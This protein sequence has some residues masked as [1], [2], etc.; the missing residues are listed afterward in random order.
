M[1]MP[2]SQRYTLRLSP[3][4]LKL[5]INVYNLENWYP[6][7][8]YKLKM[9]LAH[10]FCRKTSKKYQLNT[11]KPRKTTFSSILL[12]VSLKRNKQVESF[13]RGGLNFGI[14]KLS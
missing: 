1:A 12:I 9:W 5:D 7:C 13:A 3:I 2:D 14:G 10:Y 11:F 4:K 8:G 6:Y